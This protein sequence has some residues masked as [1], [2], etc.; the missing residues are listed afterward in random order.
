MGFNYTAV[1]PVRF[2]V[3]V[4]CSDYFV[5]AVC[6]S[7]CTLFISVVAGEN[8]GTWFVTREIQ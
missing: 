2:R 3:L 8:R 6:C 7:R 4:N 1:P 5:F